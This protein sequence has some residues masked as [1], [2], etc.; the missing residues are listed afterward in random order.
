MGAKSSFQSRRDAGV[1]L[2]EIIAALAIISVIVV[3]AL[4]LYQSAKSS[5]EA[6]RLIADAMAIQTAVRSVYMGETD[7]GVDSDALQALMWQS[8]KLPTTI[9]GKVDSAG[10]VSLTHHLGG[11]LG[12]YAMH[13]RFVILFSGIPTDVC[14]PLLAMT[15]SQ[16]QEV[17]VGNDAEGVLNEFPAGTFPISPHDAETYC[18]S[19]DSM[20]IGFYSGKY[21]P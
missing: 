21:T 14:I 19:S 16:W 13:N 18:V 2:M 5:E 10:K 12:L 20:E 17:T 11:K 4:A 1:T 3:G 8:K 6:T 15:G 9:K 7:Y